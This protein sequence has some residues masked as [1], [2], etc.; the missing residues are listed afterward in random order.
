MRVHGTGLSNDDKGDYVT[1]LIEATPAGG[2]VNCVARRFSEFVE[3]REGALSELKS[4]SCGLPPLPAKTVIRFTDDAFVS[5]RCKQLQKWLDAVQV[6]T[7]VLRTSAMRQF[8]SLPESSEEGPL[9]TPLFAL[10]AKETDPDL[11]ALGELR[12]CAL[13]TSRGAAATRVRCLFSLTLKE[14]RGALSGAFAL[15]DDL[16]VMCTG[17]NTSGRKLDRFLS[18]LF[19]DSP[20]ALGHVVLLRYDGEHLQRVTQIGLDAEIFASTYHA[21]SRCVYLAC[22]DGTVRV[23]RVTEEETAPLRVSLT[24]RFFDKNAVAV[25]VV[26][27][28]IDADGEEGFRVVAV[29]DKGVCA[30][31]RVPAP[32]LRTA[33]PNTSLTA[34]CREALSPAYLTSMQ[35]LP[36]ATEEHCAW[37]LAG[38]VN[39]RA[40]VAELHRGDT[41]TVA[42][43]RRAGEDT[44]GTVRA[45]AGVNGVYGVGTEASVVAGF[46]DGVVCHFSVDRD[47]GD[48]WFLE[49]DY[50]NGS[51][52]P[53]TALAVSSCGRFIAA[54]DMQGTLCLIDTH[55]LVRETVAT[56]PAHTKDVTRLSFAVTAADRPLLLSTS[57]DGGARA[58]ALDLQL[59]Y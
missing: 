27:D 25:D 38:A 36:P 12:H 13:T 28:G 3:A 15:H 42:E 40:L 11:A 1:Y 58:W 5:L 37:V 55:P 41:L 45:V 10:A 57:A 9:L 31:V 22:A 44:G 43:L 30:H 49:H 53:V 59:E 29:S 50:T 18:G 34:S 17:V 51:S 16:Y 8:L 52:S 23:V 47:R 39:C 14:T 56:W 24:L 2:E 4:A 7:D 46:S 6:H 32:L 26:D 21:S 33:P 54:G 35:L 20:V 48:D 19:S